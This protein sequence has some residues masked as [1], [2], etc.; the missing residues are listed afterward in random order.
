VRSTSL[1]TGAL[2]AQPSVEDLKS[3][4][5]GERV[6][7]LLQ[8]RLLA[9]VLLDSV[10]LTQ[11]F[12]DGVHAAVAQV[13]LA[14]EAQHQVRPVKRNHLRKTHNLGEVLHDVGNFVLNLNVLLKAQKVN[15]L[16]RTRF[17]KLIGKETTSGELLGVVEGKLHVVLSSQNFLPSLHLLVNDLLVHAVAGLWVQQLEVHINGLNSQIHLDFETTAVVLLNLLQSSET[18]EFSCRHNGNLVGQSFCFFH[19]V[20]GEDQSRLGALKLHGLPD[21]AAS[22]GIHASRDLIDHHHWGVA[23]HGLRTAKLTFIAATQIL[24]RFVTMVLQVE[25]LDCVV[26]DFFN[27][28]VLNTNKLSNVVQG[29]LNCETFY[30]V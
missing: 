7:D 8:S 24:C 13:V 11:L 14:S 5:G 23:K 1:Q 29:F 3:V 20:S 25:T 10:L 26:D 27:F 22:H 12:H 28:I 30:V 4:L 6:E 17:L 18:L 19:G 2:G 15:R 16:T 9:R 21:F